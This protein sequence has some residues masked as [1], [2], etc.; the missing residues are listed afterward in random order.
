MR[1]GRPETWPGYFVTRE[2]ARLHAKALIRRSITATSKA[3]REHIYLEQRFSDHAPVVIDY[4][5]TL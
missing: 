2:S 4:D 3:L 1:F 5:F